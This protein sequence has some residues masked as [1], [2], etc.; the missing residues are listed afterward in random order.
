MESIFHDMCMLNSD[1][2][3][4]AKKAIFLHMCITFLEF[5]YITT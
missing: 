3:Y 4:T 2:F 5:S 1:G